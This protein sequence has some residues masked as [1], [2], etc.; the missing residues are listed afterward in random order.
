MN[1]LTRC[2]VA[3]VT[4]GSLCT[5][6]AGAGAQ[7]MTGMK[8]GTDRYGGQSYTGAP[9]LPVTVAFVMAGG[10]PQNFHFKNALVSMAGTD[11]ITAEVGKLETQYSKA[12]V[13]QWL[14]TWDFAVGDALRQVRALGIMLPTPATLKG[15]ALASALVSAGV[16][17]DGEFWTGR[18]LDEL[19]SH[20]IHN[21]AMDDIDAKYGEPVDASYHKITNQAMFDLAQAL[22]AKSVKL[23]SFR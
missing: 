19:I 15:H 2:L 21:Q 22:G 20:K 8:G 9:N 1:I 3:L 18:M 13:A 11:L 14:T 5:F 10:G 7:P 12:A 6:A 4:A 16:A 17:N 23:A